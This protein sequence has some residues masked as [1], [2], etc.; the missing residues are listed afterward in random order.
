[1]TT[2]A[3]TPS[4]NARSVTASG[5]PTAFVDLEPVAAWILD[6]QPARYARRLATPMP[7]MQTFYDAAFPRLAEI[8]DYCNKHPIDDLPDDVKNLMHLVFS[9]IE[10]SFPIEIWK[11]GRVPDSGAAAMD[12][13]LEPAL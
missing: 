1:M 4:N 5:L 8:L 3:S 7:E 2:T 6:T 10:V 9:L 12:C 11:Q 13:I